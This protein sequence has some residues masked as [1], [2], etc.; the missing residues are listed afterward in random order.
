MATGTI[1]SLGIGSGIDSNSIV[2]QLMAIERQPLNKLDT[3]ESAFNAQISAFGTLKSRL[4]D[5]QSAAATL[6]DPN[7][8]A[9][10]AATVGDA[11]VIAAT[12]G[13]FAKEGSYAVEVV[14]LA[15]AQKSFSSLYGASTNF[16]AGTLSFNI[17]GT[18]QDV[19]I[20]SATN[21]LQDIANAVNDADIGVRATVVNGDSGSRLVLT[22]RDTGTDNAFS[23]SVTSGDANLSSLATFDT[24][25]ANAVTAQNAVIKVE[26]ETVTSQSNQVTSAIAN[27]TITAT[28]VGTS[29]LDV[30]RDNSGITDAVQSFVD[31][32]NALKTEIGTQTAYDSE[33]KTAKPL[34]GDATTRTVLNHMRDSIGLAPA[35]LSGSSFEFLYSLGVQLGQDGTL[36]F[37]SSTLDDA[38]NTDFNGVVTALG[39]YGSA[40]E[41]MATAFTQADG[42]ID[43]RVNGI[44]TSLSSIDD[45][46]T[47]LE[48]QL[49]ATETR[50]R[51]QFTALDTLMG[52]LNTTSTYLTQQLASLPGSN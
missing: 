13:T 49:T 2:T 6:A 21:S 3:K 29:T 45:Q 32:Y 5:L 39:A 9:G 17:N 26:G 16:G 46:R 8:L 38:V 41:D 40:V 11:D 10:F 31:A 27:V 24:G 20:S 14:Q 30:A 7:K 18:N 50:L 28:A 15:Q 36:S 37:N 4:S 43:N 34:N 51:A 35:S 33:T 1:S 42:L 22:S 44:E 52:S 12:A 25:N 48:Q 23:L 19:V 47:R